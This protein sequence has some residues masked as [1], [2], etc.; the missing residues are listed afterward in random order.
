[1]IHRL[2]HRAIGRL[3][4]V[5][6][7]SLTL[8]GCGMQVL[9]PAGDVARQEAHLLAITTL[10]ILLIVVPVMGLILL[11]AWRY[12]QGNSR[13]VYRPDWN[14]STALELVI[15]SVPLLIIIT[16]GAI[17]WISTHTLDPY[18]RLGRLAPGQAVPN[19]LEPLEIDVVALDWKWLFIYPGQ[20]IATLNELALPTGRE[21]RFRLT[22]SS[23]MNSF[24][25]PALAGQVYAM[26]NMETRLHA[27][28]N[29]PGRF[30]GFSAN[31]SGAGFSDMRFTATGMDEAAFDRWV[32]RRKANA[33][34]LDQAA[35]LKLARPSEDQP[36]IHW[37]SVDPD[38]FRR[39]IENCVAPGQRCMSDIMRQDMA[40]RPMAGMPMAAPATDPK[41][42]P[43]P[44]S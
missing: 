25:V 41:P 36:A 29:R 31:Y 44:Q 10:L 17:T 1:M 9:F 23:V 24:Y 5:V 22:A 8:S 12:R 11:F 20:G 35:Y 32:A 30:N 28:L 33:G 3:L 16:I 40:G 42:S 39:A 38:L 15:W 4:A 27:V 21:V 6:G 13:A 34:L 7:T 26:P 37:S 14:H 2:R 18:R 19:G 43:H